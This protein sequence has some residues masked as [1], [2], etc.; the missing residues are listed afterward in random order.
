MTD[1]L[2]KG[3]ISCPWCESEAIPARCWYDNGYCFDHCK[4]AGLRWF[5]KAAHDAMGILLSSHAR[6]KALKARLH[7]YSRITPKCV[8]CAR[9]GVCTIYGDSPLPL[10]GFERLNSESCLAP[11][12]LIITSFAK[13]VMNEGPNL[14]YTWS[15]N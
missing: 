2:A 1:L 3:L 5:R 15:Q 11:R 8:S 10:H 9:G 6:N 7:L 4:N 14:G 13:L 12:S